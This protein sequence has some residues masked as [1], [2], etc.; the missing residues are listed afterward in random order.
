MALAPRPSNRFSQGVRRARATPPIGGAARGTCAGPGESAMTCHAGRAYAPTT[1]K[2]SCE[3]RPWAWI[4]VIRDHDTLPPDDN[5]PARAFAVEEVV[6]FAVAGDD[7]RNPHHWRS[8]PVLA[9][10]PAG[11]API[12]VRLPYQLRRNG[13]EEAVIDRECVLAVTARPPEVTNQD[14]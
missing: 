12:R 10:A 7:P 13:D 9:G 6:S 5:Q 3:S 2:I 14:R 1:M 11:G 8:A 4:P